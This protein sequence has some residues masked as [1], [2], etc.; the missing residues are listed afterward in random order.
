MA[1]RAEFWEEF[2]KLTAGE[3]QL[4]TARRLGYTVSYIGQLKRRQY[5]R[6]S[7]ELVERII[8]EYRVPRNRWL[9]L[10]GY[11]EP[12]RIPEPPA[13]SREATAEELEAAVDRAVMLVTRS[14]NGAQRLTQGIF[15]LSARYGRPVPVYLPTGVETLTVEEADR[16]LAAF[17]HQ[18]L[19]D[20][21]AA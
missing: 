14:V 1:S 20:A 17:E 6:P 16:L 3:T 8:Q 4:V 10:A 9:A 2:T 5:A 13:T 21:A 12:P 19:E 18:M 7:R 11:A 15:E